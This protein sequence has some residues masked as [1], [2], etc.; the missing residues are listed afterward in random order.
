MNVRL[1]DVHAVVVRIEALERQNRR[2]KQFAASV[3][4]FLATFAVMGV[5]GPSRTIEA[6]RFVLTDSVGRTRAVLGLEKGSPTLILYTDKGKPGVQLVEYGSENPVPALKMLNANGESLADLHPGGL[7]IGASSSQNVALTL[8]IWPSLTMTDGASSVS[9][10]IRG[11]S[12]HGPSLTLVDAQGFASTLGDTV[13]TDVA[14]KKDRH[15]SSASLVMEDRDGTI[16]WSAETVQRQIDQIGAL[17]AD[18][19]SRI[20]AI[21]FGYAGANPVKTELDD[22]KEAVCPVLR[23]ARI[24]EL[25]KIKLDS[26]CGLH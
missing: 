15:T 17:A 19:D 9:L 16:L 13:L 23:T 21:Q 24:G 1:Q 12:G 7:Y 20:R 5:S 10:S 6:Q 26:A 14:T 11:V 2:L 22:F 4:L 8:G 3:L 18:N 25:T